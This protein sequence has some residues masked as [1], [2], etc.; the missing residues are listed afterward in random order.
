MN[1]KKFFQLMNKLADAAKESKSKY[2]DYLASVVEQRKTAEELA[3][4]IDEYTSK[5]HIEVEDF[6]IDG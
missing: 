2:L 5:P 3:Q 1:H 6:E 4:F